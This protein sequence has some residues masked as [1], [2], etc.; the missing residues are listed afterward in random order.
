MLL[1]TTEHTCD[2]SA[3]TNLDSAI[4]MILAFIKGRQLAEKSSSVRLCN[5]YKFFYHLKLLIELFVYLFSE[6]ISLSVDILIVEN[7]PL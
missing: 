4:S 1:L 5:T 6:I 7:Y 3:C 2:V